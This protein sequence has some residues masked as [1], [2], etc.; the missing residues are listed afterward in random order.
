MGLIAAI[1]SI[2]SGRLIGR[3]SPRKILIVASLGAGIMY[4]LPIFAANT[5]QLVIFVG[6][7]GLLQGSVVTSTTSLIGISVPII[8]QGMAYGLSQSANALGITLGPIIGGSVA[9]L[10]SLRYI[11]GLSAG[12]FLITGLLA[13]KFV[14]HGAPKE[15]VTSEPTSNKVPVPKS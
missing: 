13:S 5:T 10:M 8:Q 12:I 6:L 4:I 11:F 7:L 3:I 9:Q 1:S 15:E 14:V 2:V